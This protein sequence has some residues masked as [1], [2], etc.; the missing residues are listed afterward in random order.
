M[1]YVEANAQAAAAAALNQTRQQVR[2][3][4]EKDTTFIVSEKNV[5]PP[6]S[7]ERF[8]EMTQEVEG[9][10]WDVFLISETL[11]ASNAEIW[12]TQQGH[13]FMGSGKFENKHRVGI[14]VNKKWRKRVNWTDYINERAIST[15]ITV[16]KQHVLLMRVYF[17]SGHADHHVELCT[18]QSKSRIP[19]KRT[20]K[21]WEGISM[22]SWDQGMEF[23]RVS[24]GPHTLEEEN[25]RGYWM[26]QCLMT[27]NLTALNT[28]CRTTLEKQASYRTGTEKQLDFI[29]VDRKTYVLQKRR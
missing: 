16:N 10:R 22:P 3:K 9:C 7:S 14:L 21:L 2:Q 29:L 15:S 27:Q 24:V 20:Y 4:S 23:E 28:M 13:I 19:R 26:K 8:E 6:N 5:R 18:E 12:E 17:S 1:F 11:R 25:K